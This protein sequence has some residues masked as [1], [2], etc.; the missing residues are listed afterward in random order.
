MADLLFRVSKAF[1]VALAV[2]LVKLFPPKHH[3]RALEI[4]TDVMSQDA[5]N[6][7]CL[8]SLGHILQCSG[9]W[10]DAENV[11]KRVSILSPD[12]DI[13]LEAREEGA[14]CIVQSGGLEEGIA[15]L[16]VVVQALDGEEGKAE[17]KA[18]AWWRL[19]KSLWETGGALPLL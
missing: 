4:V 8:M 3:V 6:I 9:Q 14:W 1:K 17:Q 16:E 12:H 10:S 2:G 13:G 15:E 11:F 18:R 7:P 19:G 5:D